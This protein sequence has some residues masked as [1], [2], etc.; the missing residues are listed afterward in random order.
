MDAILEKAWKD[1]E[2][3]RCVSNVEVQSSNVEDYLCRFCG[4]PKT[5]DGVE[6]DL[7]TCTQCGAQ[8]NAFISDEP[9]WRTGAEDTGEIDPTR[10]GGPISGELFSRQWEM[11][12]MITGN[13]T[14]KKIQTHQ[15]M[16][17]KD[18]ALFHAYS[19]MDRIGKG[20]LALP[21]TVMYAAKLKYKGFTEAVLTRGAVRNGIKA[22]CI[23]QACKEMGCPRTTQEIADAFGIPPRDISRTF[24]MYQEQNP[25]TEV[26]VTKP[27]D[28]VPRFVN[29]ITIVPEESKGRVRMQIIKKCNELEECVELMGRTPKAIC[30]AV[31]YLTL[32]NMNLKPDKKEICK[33]CDIS[34]P[35]LVKIETIIKKLKT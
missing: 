16:N 11:N 12:T 26:H 25:E 29:H 10:T 20:T 4:H 27:A 33:I 9:E 32:M 23:F 34:E 15:A 19:E 5:F 3:L 14:M 1:F 18:R 31:I 7:P 8:D 28:L 6:V 21:E 13:S 24:D 30:C 22:N 2:A 17:H 35:T